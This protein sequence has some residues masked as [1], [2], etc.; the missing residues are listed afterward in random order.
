MPFITGEGRGEER[1]EVGLGERRGADRG[2]SQ[3]E[4]RSGQRWVSGRAEERTEVGLGER[5]GADR[6]G[7]GGRERG[8]MR[9]TEVGRMLSY[10]WI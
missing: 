3:R 1:T 2:G 8:E 5:R 9:R 7:S 6:G 10:L 4:Q